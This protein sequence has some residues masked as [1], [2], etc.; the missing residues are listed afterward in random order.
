M[1]DPEVDTIIETI[2]QLS[3]AADKILDTEGLQ[4]EEAFSGV[5]HYLG[6]YCDSPDG[7]AVILDNDTLQSC[8]QHIISGLGDYY[9]AIEFL[10]IDLDPIRNLAEYLEEESLADEAELI[11]AVVDFVDEIRQWTNRQS[12]IVPEQPFTSCRRPHQT[13]SGNLTQDQFL[14]LF[15]NRN[16]KPH[17]ARLL[18]NHILEVSGEKSVHTYYGALAT[19]CRGWFKT[20]EQD[21]ASLL[22]NF[23]S[24]AGL[25]PALADN[26]RQTK[27]GKK[28]IARAQEKK[29]EISSTRAKN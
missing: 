22:R 17:K 5:R 10:D 24:V 18:L 8:R 15:D 13:G 19:E 21:F 12:D 25:D 2:N 3:Q 20:N 1:I 6:R 28:V 23:L 26:V 9:S 11:W 29:T 27:L 14:A 4:P 7:I 16:C